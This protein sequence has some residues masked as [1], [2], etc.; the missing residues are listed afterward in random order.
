MCDIRKSNLDIKA[1]TALIEDIVEME[2]VNQRVYQV[3]N[4]ESKTLQSDYKISQAK[5]LLSVL[6]CCNRN[7]NLP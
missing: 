2:K 7:R 4:D 5:L 3:L 6:R 1:V